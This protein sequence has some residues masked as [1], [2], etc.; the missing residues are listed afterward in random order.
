MK[1]VILLD[2]PHPF[3]ANTY[4]VSVC[5]EAAVVDPT[6]PYSPEIC[7][8]KLK[9]IL[10]THA[11]FDHILEVESW[12][13]GTGAEVIVLDAER[14]A[15]ADPM[16]NCFKLYDGTDRGYFGE[17]REVSEGDTLP[18][19]DTYIRVIACPGHTIGCA[20]YVIDDIAFVGDTVFERGGFGRYDLPTGSLV[21]LKE[22]IRKII[23]LPDETILYP[24]HGGTT[25]VRE[26]KNH[27]ILR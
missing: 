17:A 20:T 1:K 18:L 2:S 10:L 13:E 26:Y 21:M 5:Q 16:R 9:Y 14:A 11:H 7:P 3:A 25:T 6:A 4:L 22:S 15:L 12:R 23:S 27:L 19:G 8:Y 24:G